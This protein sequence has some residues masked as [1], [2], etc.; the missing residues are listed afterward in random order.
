MHH[1]AWGVAIDARIHC[2]VVVVLGVVGFKC[3]GAFEHDPCHE[4]VSDSPVCVGGQVMR[5]SVV[6]I[7]FQGRQCRF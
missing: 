5:F 7:K 3:D 4:V 6:G 1:G 2:G